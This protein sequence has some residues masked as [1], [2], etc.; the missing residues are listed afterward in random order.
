MEGFHDSFIGDDEAGIRDLF[1][2]IRP[3]TV[4]CLLY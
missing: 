3:D 4:L 1:D 2:R